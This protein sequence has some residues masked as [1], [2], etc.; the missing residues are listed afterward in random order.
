MTSVLDFGHSLAIA[1]ALGHGAAATGPPPLIE[2]PALIAA[3]RAH[4]RPSIDI[5]RWLESVHRVGRQAGLGHEAGRIFM[6]RTGRAYAPLLEERAHIVARAHDAGVA[7]SVAYFMAHAES[8]ALRS[9][10]GRAAVFGDVA[11]AQHLGAPAAA[12]LLSLAAR[13]PESRI[14]EQL[15]DI[16]ARAAELAGGAGRWMTARQVVAGLASCLAPAPTDVA[17]ARP[18]APRTAVAGWSTRISPAA[19]P[20]AKPRSV[21][22]AGRTL[23]TLGRTR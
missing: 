3:C 16:A 11:V 14:E 7:A 5:P 21:E 1:L 20:V 17:A 6:T 15:P 18:F 9:A 12:R 22:P 23:P 4:T 19:P 2:P 10:L 8:A 13:S